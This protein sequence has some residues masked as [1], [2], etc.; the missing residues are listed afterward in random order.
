MTTSTPIDSTAATPLRKDLLALTPDTLAVLANRGLVR[1]AAKELEAGSVPELGTAPDGSVEA[2]FADGTETRLA[3]GASLDTGVC[4]CDATGVCRHLVGLVLAYQRRADAPPPEA[5]ADNW[6]PGD[7]D[8]A[9]LA[10]AVG[11]RALAAARRTARRGATVRVHRPTTQ[12]PVPWVE[13]PTCT[14]RFPVPGEAAHALTDALDALR[15][16]MLALAIWAFRAADTADAEAPLVLVA[17]QEPGAPDV[18][19]AVQLRDQNNQP[20]KQAPTAPPPPRASTASLQRAVDLADELLWEGIVHSGPVQRATLRRIGQLLTTASLHWPAAAVVDLVDQLG[21]YSGR[22]ALHRPDEVAALLAELHARHRA[23]GHPEVLGSQESAETP[24][25]RVR[26]TAL[27]CRVSGSPERPMAE[28]YFAHAAAG[29]VLVL[30]K[31][32]PDS[33]HRNTAPPPAGPLRASPPQAG[34]HQPLPPPGPALASRRLL[35]TTLSALATGNL[36]SETARRTP[37]RRLSLTRGR[38]AATTVTPVGRAWSELPEP[39]LVRDVAQYTASAGGRPPRLIRA[40]VEAESVRVVE[41]S[42]VERIGYDP[43]EQRLEADVRD[44]TGHRVLVH[45]THNPLCPNA[46]D[47]LAEALARDDVQYVS[48]ALDHAQGRLCIT[49]FALL[50][51]RGVLV[52]DLTVAAAPCAL[53][54]T[55][56]APPDLTAWA[57]EAAVT[58]LADAAHHGLRHL[59]RSALDR[60][61]QAADHLTRAGLSESSARLRALLDALRHEDRDTATKAWTDACIRLHVATEL[62]AQERRAQ[63]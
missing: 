22:S 24:L 55:E 51:P 3:P 13:L 1:R 19:D 38:L 54:P 8:D 5:A 15:G 41:L 57:L 4:G 47:A 7:I 26:L 29:V 44:A 28:L 62:T 59:P 46:L 45:A 56:P 37:S 39:L 32:W 9:A 12:D 25:R 50:G 30:R 18:P 33:A 21:A 20:Q 10:A 36:V 53:P 14:V 48:G 2:R 43:A 63:E 52:P 49:P 16:E 11:A 34:G 61:H 31:D 17:L 40:R 23:S 27:G 60:V 42:K 6:S 58:A 35:G